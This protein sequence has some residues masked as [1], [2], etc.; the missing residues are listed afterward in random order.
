MEVHAEGAVVVNAQPASDKEAVLV[1]KLLLHVGPD[2]FRDVGGIAG[3]RDHTRRNRGGPRGE[4]L[5]G[6]PVPIQHVLQVLRAGRRTRREHRA[7]LERRGRRR[8]RRVVEQVAA[9]VDLEALLDFREV[10]ALASLAE[11]AVAATREI[12]SPGE[13]HREPA[14]GPPVGRPAPDETV[15]V[16]LHG[17]REEFPRAKGAVSEQP[18][19]VGA[20]HVVSETRAPQAI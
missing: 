13:S 18:V 7:Q 14:R 19:T 15:D 6:G 2:G 11:I 1:P 9:V 20:Q 5:A 12:Q 17:L 8:V 3:V 10:H 16:L 4:V